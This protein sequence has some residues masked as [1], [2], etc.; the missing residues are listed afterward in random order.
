M[1]DGVRSRYPT[2]PACVVDVV[3]A[4]VTRF[5]YSPDVERIELKIDNLVASSCGQDLSGILGKIAGRESLQLVEQVLVEEYTVRFMSGKL[6]RFTIGAGD[7]A[8]I[9]REVV[10][11]A[12][13]V[14]TH[15][16]HLLSDGQEL[17]Y[18]DPVPESADAQIEAVLGSETWETNLLELPDG[19][20]ELLREMSNFDM[21]SRD[22]RKWADCGEFT[23]IVLLVKDLCI[24][25][26]TRGAT[27][28]DDEDEVQAEII[29]VLKAL[30]KKCRSP[31]SVFRE[32][33]N[34]FGA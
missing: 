5:G 20:Q 10:A 28:N 24:K 19:I 8:G 31:E 25:E 14:H 9:L 30:I 27:V 12:N 23:D 22:G 11:D 33:R 34:E 15:Q 18:G 32:L 7:N 21:L 1:A 29:V 26:P 17:A 16:V 2:W 13:E 4:L 6:R 3:A